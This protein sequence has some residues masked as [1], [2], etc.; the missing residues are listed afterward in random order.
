MTPDKI[1]AIKARRW[2]LPPDVG[3]GD[4]RVKQMRNDLDDLLAEVKRANDSEEELS[5]KC[6]EFEQ[7]VKDVYED[8]QKE[9]A[10][11]QL[12][13]IEVNALRIENTRYRKALEFYA[14]NEAYLDGSPGEWVGTCRDDQE[15]EHDEGNVAR[16]ALSV[17]A[18]L[19]EGAES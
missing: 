15:W 4:L 1:Q 7:Q 18:S 3:Y 8:A 14:D 9:I 6:G 17:Q 16:E 11:L 2:S 13:Q 12:T 10:A 19:G 5:R